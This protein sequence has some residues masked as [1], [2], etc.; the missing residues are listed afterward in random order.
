FHFYFLF[1]YL[2]FFVAEFFFCCPFSNE[3]IHTFSH[4]ITMATDNISNGI[5]IFYVS[6]K[7]FHHMKHHMNRPFVSV[8]FA[9]FIFFVYHKNLLGL[10]LFETFQLLLVCQSIITLSFSFFVQGFSS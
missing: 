4:S 7:C 8:F 2:F 10:I 9:F 3:S 6:T 5:A 1:I